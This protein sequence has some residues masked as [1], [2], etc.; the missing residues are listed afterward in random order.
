VLGIKVA[1]VYV[2]LGF[3]FRLCHL[4]LLTWDKSLVAQMVKSLPAMQG[5]WGISPGEG[6]GNQLQYSC[7]KNPI[8]R[9]AWW[10]TD[11]GVTK[12]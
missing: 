7:L 10:A 5:I 8:D 1:L 2:R 6:N 9:G 12:S 11:H 4:P 3:E